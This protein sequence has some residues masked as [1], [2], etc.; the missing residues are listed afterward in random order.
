M[1]ITKFIESYTERKL[2]EY[3]K[4]IVEGMH[5]QAGVSQYLIMPRQCESNLNC[6]SL[7]NNVK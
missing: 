1:D 2:S 3:Q 4:Q 6:I 5:K 7:K